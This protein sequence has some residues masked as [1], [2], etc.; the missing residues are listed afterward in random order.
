MKRTQRR[1]LDA[2]YTPELLAERLVSV[3]PIKVY[4]IAWEPH[5]GGGAF[6][7]ALLRRTPH[8]RVTDLDPKAPGLALVASNAA[9][10]ADFL[11]VE[12]RVDWIVGNPPF[13]GFENHVTHALECADNV[14]FLLRLGAL[15][16]QKRIDLW[17]RWPLRQLWVLA[18][19][20]SFTGGSTDN[21][22]YGW[23]WFQ[24]GWKRAAT[25]VPGWS[26][27]R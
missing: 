24:R 20:P 8:V 14:A 13:T 21:S 4:E 10:V 12:H 1:E 11:D 17:E 2:Y 23:F 6:A 9:E 19:R 3:L 25:I 26:W 18:E 7:Q 15:A 22:D 16:A 5:V 27:K